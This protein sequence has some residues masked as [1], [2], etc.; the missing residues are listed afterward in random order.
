LRKIMRREDFIRIRRFVIEQQRLPASFDFCS[1]VGLRL[2]RTILHIIEIDWKVWTMIGF[3]VILLEVLVQIKSSIILG[4]VMI[5]YVI[6]EWIV[7]LGVMAM[8]IKIRRATAELANFEFPP[9]LITSIDNPTFDY[10]PPKSFIQKLKKTFCPCLDPFP[11]ETS[12]LFWF[13]SRG[14]FQ[15]LIQVSLLSQAVNFALLS[16][17]SV[18]ISEVIT[19]TVLVLCLLLPAMWII[20]FAIPYIVP[21]F[22]IVSNS[23]DYVDRN[24]IR[25]ILSGHHHLQLKEHSSSHHSSGD[26]S[27][28]KR[29]RVFVDPSSQG[30]YEAPSSL[31]NHL[32]TPLLIH[33]HE[34]EE[35]L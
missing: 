33:S 16:L 7:L 12:L 8:L 13:R 5:I 21:V 6:T 23:G 2:Q 22:S 25:N 11:H 30:T 4:D 24:E 10:I 1:Y 27:F 26:G 32:T 29:R 17:F 9:R 18:E 34:V 20:V 15:G 14:F 19:P 31:D 3:F 28:G 35:G